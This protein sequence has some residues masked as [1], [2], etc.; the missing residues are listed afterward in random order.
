MDYKKMLLDVIAY[1]QRQDVLSND[2]AVYEELS[3]ITG[4]NANEIESELF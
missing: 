3:Y 4:Y 2:S 1:A